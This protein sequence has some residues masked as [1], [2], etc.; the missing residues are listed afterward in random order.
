[1]TTKMKVCGTDHQMV[2]DK[3]NKGWEKYCVLLDRTK[4]RALSKAYR[5]LGGDTEEFRRVV[6]VINDSVEC[7]KSEKD[8]PSYK[9]YMAAEKIDSLDFVC[10]SVWRTFMNAFKKDPDSSVR[11]LPDE[12][13]VPSQCSRVPVSRVFELIDKKDWASINQGDLNRIERYLRSKK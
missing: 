7:L 5:H 6:K 8:L 4:R 2:G 13:L 1:M 9:R 11:E 10:E 3:R 12:I